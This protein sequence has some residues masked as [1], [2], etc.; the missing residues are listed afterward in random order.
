MVHHTR[1][2]ADEITVLD[3]IPVTTIPRTLFDL[4]A[5]LDTRQVERAL[6]EADYLRLADRLS[7][8]DLLARHPRRAGAVNLARRSPLAR[9]RH[10]HAQ[11]ARG[12]LPPPARR[13]A[14]PR[15]QVNTLV[16]GLRGGLR[17]AGGDGSS[18]ELDGRAAHAT[19]AAFEADRERDRVLQAAGWRVVRVTW[20]QLTERPGPPRGRPENPAGGL[21]RRYRL[22]RTCP[23]SPTP[24]RSAATGSPT[25][26][27][28]APLAGIGNWFVRL[29]AKRFG[30]GL[31]T[32]EMVSSFG[33]AYGNKRTV[34]EFL[35]IH[36]DEHPVSIQLFGQDADVMRRA[37]AMAAEAGADLIDLN[38]GCPVKKVCKTGAG[39]ALLDDPDRAVA[40]A[41]AA[42]EGS[43]P[44]GDREAA[45]RPAARRARRRRTWPG[46]SWRRPA[47]RASASTRGTRRSSTPGGPT[48]RSRASSW[49]S[50]PRR[51]S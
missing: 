37:A 41:R 27:V 42:G 36:P 2:P 32:S 48:T 31:V 1:L 21:G 8:P 28:L 30:A 43:R 11:R 22:P 29:Q 47:W 44:A 12:A 50:C 10:P 3:G 38:M 33:L 40:V 25:A 19:P 7:L 18:L 23:R 16:P 49:S 46:A 15:P 26:L 24:G 51:W 4:A 39:A 13:H 45:A 6:N 35:R 34:D 17:V 5:V 9:R 14:F 20:R